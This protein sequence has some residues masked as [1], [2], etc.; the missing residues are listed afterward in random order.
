M[1]EPRLLQGQKAL[2]QSAKGWYQV[3][4]AWY[5]PAG[6]P[7]GV[8]AGSAAVSRR[9]L[10]GRKGCSP[11]ELRLVWVLKIIYKPFLLF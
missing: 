8:P 5:Q 1:A 6:R 10:Q 4:R 2:Q 3:V 9:L 7:V 11:V